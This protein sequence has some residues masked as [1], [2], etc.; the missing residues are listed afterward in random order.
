VVIALLAVA[1]P[2]FQINLTPV[3]AA[4]LPPTN[5][6]GA[7]LRPDVSLPSP[8]SYNSIWVQLEARGDLP[9]GAPSPR[10]GA[11]MVYDSSD[12]K[13]VLF[14]GTPGCGDY[15]ATYGCSYD[16]DTWVLDVSTGVWNQEDPSS[17]PPFTGGGAMAYD[18]ELNTILYYGGNGNGD[19][20][21]Q[22]VGEVGYW[23]Y[24]PSTDTWTQLATDGIT[25]PQTGLAIENGVYLV[26]DPITD[27]LLMTGGCW[28]W[29]PAGN[30]G[31][32][33]S[34]TSWSTFQWNGG[35]SWTELESPQNPGLYA[36][37]ALEAEGID[38]GSTVSAGGMSFT[39]P[40]ASAGSDGAIESPVDGKGVVIP[41]PDATAGATTLGIL[42]AASNGPTTGT[43]TLT[44]TDESTARVSLGL[45]DSQGNDGVEYDNSTVATM[46]Y[47]P[48]GEYGINA[49][50]TYLYEASVPLDS[51]KTLASI[52]LPATVNQ[53]EME[54]F[55]VSTRTT[56]TG[57][58]TDLYNTV[59]A[60]LVYPAAYPGDDS[61]ATDST[62]GNP[63]FLTGSTTWTWDGSEWNPAEVS[64]PM[65]STDTPYN[66]VDDPGRGGVMLFGGTWHNSGTGTLDAT[67]IWNGTTWIQQEPELASP[68]G[69]PAD[70]ANTA[71]VYDSSANE[72]IM[73]GGYSDDSGDLNDTWAWTSSGSWV[74][75]GPTPPTMQGSATAYDAATNQVVLF[76][77][78]DWNGTGTGTAEF[79]T[80]DS[81]YLWDASTGQWSQASP[82]DSPPARS[83]ESMAYD[84]ETKQVLMF[85]GIGMDDDDSTT[86]LD[87]TWAWNGTNWSQLS[88]TDSPPAADTTAMAYDS[89]TGQM[90]LVC[91][92]SCGD[93]TTWSWTGS[94][95][96]SVGSDASL[97]QGSPALAYDPNSGDLLL[98]V[99]S[100]TY[101]WDGTGWSSFSDSNSPGFSAAG[102]AYDPTS[103]FMVLYDQQDSADT[104]LWDETADDW[105]ATTTAYDQTDPYVAGGDVSNVV[106]NQ[107][108]TTAD[109]LVDLD[110][111][112]NTWGYTAQP[113][114]P[115]AS[116][117]VGGSNAVE[118]ATTCPDCGGPPIN[119]GTGEF[120]QQFTDFNIPG[121]GINLNFTRTYSSSLDSQT[122]PLGFGW[123]D[124]YNVHLT[125]DSSGD[126]TIHLD[127]GATA[128]FTAVGNMFVASPHSFATLV[129]NSDGTYTFTNTNG[130]A[131]T[132]DVFSTTGQLTKLIDRDGY[133]TTLSYNGSDQ[134]TTV[135]DPAGRTLTYTYNS[136]GHIATIT[137]PD[138]RVETF[139][140][141][142][143]GDLT[144]AT[145]PNSGV[146][147]FAY[148]G[149]NQMTSVTDPRKDGSASIGY[150]SNGQA[151]SYTD[152]M[153]RET[154]YQYTDN[155]GGSTTTTITDPL[156][157]VTVDSYQYLELMSETQGY[158]TAE[159]ATTQ[160]T[161]S[162]INLATTSITDPD[163]NVTAY[164]YDVQ[165]NLLTKTDPLQQTT[166][167]TY[168]AENDVLSTT[169]PL[170][171]TTTNTYDQYGNLLSTSTPSSAG[172]STTSYTYDPSHPG[173]I[174]TETDPNGN[175]TGF[176][177]DS[178]GDK[179]SETSPLGEETTWTY[180]VIGEMLT[181]VSPN[182][183]V[184]G[185]TPSKFT[186]TYTY[187]P[188]GDELTVKD[189]L[190]HTTTY[191]YDADQNRTVVK[192]ALGDTTTTTYD[193]DSEATKV[194][195]ANSSGTV[196]ETTST[197]YDSDGNVLTQT[198][199]TG[200]VTTYTYDP[201][202]LVS[203]VKTPLGKTTSYSYD[204]DGDVLTVT[205]PSGRVT[206]NGYDADNELTSIAYS[207]GK[208]PDVGYTY[209]A[210]GQPLTMTDGTGATSYQW[211]QMHNLLSV[212]N[213]AGNTVNYGYDLAG[214]ETSIQYPGGGTVNRNYNE[215]EE[216]SSVSDWLGNTT[217]VGYD[218][219]GNLTSISYPDTVTETLTY[220]DANLVTKIADKAGSK[221]LLS[222]SYTYNADNQLTAQGSASAAYTNL[223]QV[224]S[225]SLSG[226][227]ISYTYDN[228]NRLSTV[229]AGS[230]ST[231][232]NYN[233]DSELTTTKSGSATTTYSF[234]ADGDR[235]S[236]TPATGSAT[237][238]S[239]DQAGRLTGVSTTGLS[240]SYAYNGDGLRMSKTVNGTTEQYSWDQSGSLPLL[241]QDGATS[242]IY[243]TGGLT[244]EQI[245]GSGNPTYYLHDWQGS[246]LGLVSSS[247]TVVA[248]YT[249]DAY[250][251]LTSS[252][253]TATTPLLFQGQYRDSETGFYYLQARY[254][255]P[256][257]GQFL[258]RDPMAASTGEPYAFCADD[259]VN[260]SD[261]S[262][263][264]FREGEFGAG[265]GSPSPSSTTTAPGASARFMPASVSPSGRTTRTVAKRSSGG[266]SGF[267][268]GFTSFLGH[269][270]GAAA[271]VAGQAAH[272]VAGV[273]AAGAS[274][275][276]A[277]KGTILVVGLLTVALVA[278]IA[279]TGGLGGLAIYGA[280][281]EGGLAG[282]YIGIVGVQSAAASAIAPYMIAQAI[283]GQITGR[284][285]G[286]IFP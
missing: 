137:D 161:Y 55:A 130:S 159:A 33:W 154:T 36:E 31:N 147:T 102:L 232:L 194:A 77:G 8:S 236:V 45:S 70:R 169:D 98:F 119:T 264:D 160:Y 105:V 69:V 74:P 51:S 227:S 241:I 212:T 195:Q 107:M 219:N 200:D 13:V 229:T 265:G 248:S 63:V 260:D 237:N 182:G 266:C 166:T 64:V 173:D 269:A 151:T 19:Y 211:D 80:S 68:E 75:L 272:D 126:A 11:L 279:L 88:P 138:K 162:P 129:K 76:G 198:D 103:G 92:T 175:T 14:G 230:S 274:W 254:Y 54:V 78:T 120:W 240:A 100:S 104:Y 281:Q 10:D 216:L 189:P 178:Y 131:Q 245:D 28:N 218:A 113:S 259:P 95:W 116:E 222:N 53:G 40:S 42:G 136:G 268:C 48:S 285:L 186:T 66:L 58:L 59:G 201:L 190:G 283:R 26:W 155:G 286:Q 145:N 7:N 121:R 43:A 18:P 179:A 71:I 267:F 205:D 243:G 46:S 91:T 225:S 101:G 187:D 73:F 235:T 213:G 282:T 133:T 204:G 123:T 244:L 217:Q 191:T 256:A 206:T 20:S 110:D 15:N 176:T 52:T 238:Y 153:G 139:G 210:D 276:D 62:S 24:D 106:G 118:Y 5:I 89:A 284:P 202:N 228:A 156:K 6:S 252:S 170:G 4:S 83:F 273:A 275:A 112:G 94:S 158:G 49:G 23:T 249:Y 41:T 84:P 108:T 174:E 149:A 185:G 141:N 128:T 22:N 65:Q 214:N 246:T 90:I 35:T 251:N 144:T 82:S 3:S 38:P 270:A 188:L 215:D 86:D 44:Y 271:T 122:G 56:A 263:D 140:Y 115:S 99:D 34:F 168:D 1:V 255:D 208:T 81:T 150:N 196:L 247:G 177:Y 79:P 16:D 223:H 199:G 67:W 171:N 47:S 257:T 37:Q 180:N 27:H 172:T 261:P 111:W 224:S 203:S 25:D 221:S 262:G 231:T 197:S 184:P 2:A 124:N 132:Q 207:D 163:N 93:D 220:N 29:A 278:S 117:T 39:W 233:S 9:E 127:T 96:D 242:F 87:D 183:N 109:Y 135:T 85:G 181:M 209:D 226:S 61:I 239:Y 50:D 143:S 114:V 165:G 12:N 157:N 253:G 125:F 57:D 192:D 164:T 148:N 60:S 250:G 142:T 167:Y 97:A 234:D 193:A 277:H 134:L 146:W 30:S 280:I 258:T 17:S 152:P 72:D 21:G 32:C